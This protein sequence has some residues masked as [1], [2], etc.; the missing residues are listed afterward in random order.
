VSEPTAR[1][2]LRDLAAELGERTILWRG[3]ELGGADIDLLATDGSARDVARFLHARGLEPTPGDPGHVVWSAPGLKPIDVLDERAWP[4]H[5]PSLAGLRRRLVAHAD[6]PPEPAPED[7][8]LI[9]GAEAVAGRPV[10]KLVRRARPLLAGD[11]VPA[12]LDALARDEGAEAIAALIADPAALEARAARG[13]LP[14]PAAAAVAARSPRARLALAARVAGRLSGGR[15]TG[16][17]AARPRRPLLV[18]LS[19]MD[20]AGKSTAAEAIRAHLE[21]NGL[22]A[23]IEW[24]RIGG[25]SQLLDTLA[26]PVKRILRRQGTVADP[27]A[28]GGPDVGKVQDPR[29]A[30]GTRSAITWTWV[31]IVA[32]ANARSYRQ[33][34]RRRQTGVSVV[35]DRWVTDA[36]VDLDL[37]YGKHPA[38]TAVLR[39]LA[40]RT[41]LSVLLQISAATAAARKPG[42][43]AL[44]VLEGMEQRYA[45]QARDPSIA[46]VDA[47]RPPPDVTA[48][49]LALVDQLL[50]EQAIAE[51]QGGP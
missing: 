13:R 5:Y 46:V 33:A 19:G 21:A 14:Y 15:S 16:P 42:D 3:A 49:V 25:E 24:A 23:R 27:V 26:T 37:R 35:A 18:T 7:R 28:A 30:S 9:L 17:A 29:A 22:P 34:A 1:E 39:R 2:L 40:P 44:H 45:E 4:R 11:G 50:D 36:L 38:A 41:D 31:V 12:R 6:L 32:A 10:E 48:A 43:Q 20:G 47:T 51:R 8:L